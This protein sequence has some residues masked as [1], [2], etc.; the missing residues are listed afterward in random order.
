[1]LEIECVNLEEESSTPNFASPEKIA[2]ATSS[3]IP[4]IQFRL[5]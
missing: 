2:L 3:T 5:K 4:S 1:V